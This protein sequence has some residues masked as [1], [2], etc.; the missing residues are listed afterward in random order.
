MRGGADLHVK[1][2]RWRLQKHARGN[3]F[4]TFTENQD[5]QCAESV[6]MVVDFQLGRLKNTAPVHDSEL[7]KCVDFLGGLGF[8]LGCFL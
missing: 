1:G 7:R 3:V 8:T 2:S 5:F 4:I 6:V